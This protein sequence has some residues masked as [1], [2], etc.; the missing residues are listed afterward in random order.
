MLVLHNLL[1]APNVDYEL[2]TVRSPSYKKE[3]ELLDRAQRGATK[4][5]PSLRGQPYEDRLNKLNHCTL[6]K[7]R[8]RDVF[9]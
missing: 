5:I 8:L 6:E 3:V 7:R 1:V 4:V 2:H 9:R